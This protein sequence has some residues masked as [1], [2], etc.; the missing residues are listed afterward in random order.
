M[1]KQQDI[2]YYRMKQ[3]KDVLFFN[4][5][6]WLRYTLAAMF[7]INLNWLLFSLGYSIVLPLLLLILGLLSLFEQV[8]IYGKRDKKT[9]PFA[10][11]Y[12]ISQSF[13]SF[14]GMVSVLLNSQLFKLYPF[15]KTSNEAIWFIVGLNLI[16]ITIC[17]LNLRHLRKVSLKQDK[18]YSNVIKQF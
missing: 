6:L 18:F 1:V 9:L 8:M 17:L 12:F 4:R 5:F 11:C 13:I 16:L 10:K 15:L 2:N 3:S 14:L 7:F